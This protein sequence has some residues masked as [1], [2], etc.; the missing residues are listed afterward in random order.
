MRALASIPF[1]MLWNPAMPMT[2]FLQ[3]FPELGTRETR[4]LTVAGRDDLPDGNYGLI[5][6]YCNEPNCDCRRVMVFVLRPDTGWNPWATI[7]YDWE[8]LD[9]YQK[10]A[11]SSSQDRFHWQ[12]PFLDPLG[13][14]TQYSP[15]FLDLFQFLLQ[16]PDYVQRLKDH[17]RLFRAAVEDD[18]PTSNGQERHPVVSRS[19]R[20]SDPKRPAHGLK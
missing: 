10:W 14:Q 16:S 4:S 20:R 8:S 18:S 12:G 6:L 7:N 2:P 5:E 9:F 11:R 19:T 3:R 1:L 17:Y 13:A 15:L